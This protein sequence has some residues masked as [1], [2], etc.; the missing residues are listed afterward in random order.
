MSNEA[1]WGVVVQDVLFID[2]ISA[3]LVINESNYIIEYR[4]NS[5]Q[6]DFILPQL[7]NS[8]L[9]HILWLFIAIKK[10]K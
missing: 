7:K 1:F 2:V 6:I 5:L 8:L 9:N 3:S 4:F 10:W